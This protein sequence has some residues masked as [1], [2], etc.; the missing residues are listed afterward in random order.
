MT[1]CIVVGEYRRLGGAV[2]LY[3]QALCSFEPVTPAYR[4][5]RTLV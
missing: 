5:Y 3:F 1:P 2:G 4:D